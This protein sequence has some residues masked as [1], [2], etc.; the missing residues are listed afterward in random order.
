M[1]VGKLAVPRVV[2]RVA[3]WRSGVAGGRYPKTQLKMLLKIKCTVYT[4][5]ATLA[6]LAAHCS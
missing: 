2:P 1:R 3:D 5:N 4:C 6:N